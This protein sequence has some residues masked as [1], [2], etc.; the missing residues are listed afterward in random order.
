MIT[1][2]LI[3]KHTLQECL[4]A[5]SGEPKD[6]RNTLEGQFELLAKKFLYGG[7]F[8]ILSSSS[9]TRKVRTEYTIISSITGTTI[10]RK[11]ILIRSLLILQ[12]V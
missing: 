7:Y 8:Y 5:F 2:E 3:K 1:E 12:A 6:G 4:E 10:T 11:S 9:I